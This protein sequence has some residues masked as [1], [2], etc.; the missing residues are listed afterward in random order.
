MIFMFIVRNVG[1]RNDSITRARN[2]HASL[3]PEIRNRLHTCILY[4]TCLH[5]YTHICLMRVYTVIEIY[6]HR[7]GLKND[8]VGHAAGGR[9]IPGY[10]CLEHKSVTLTTAAITTHICTY[11][12]IYI[13]IY[14]YIYISICIYTAI[15]S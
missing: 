1:C 14:I 15:Y 7:Y 9:G 4:N 11:I 2:R 13:C 12:Y 3:W 5:A 10:S 6:T 8:T